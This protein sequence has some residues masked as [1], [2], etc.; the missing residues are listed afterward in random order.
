MA[1]GLC[2]GAG[3]AI[4]GMADPQKVLAFLT[5]GPDWA[6]ALLLVMGSA[7]LT[8][9]L[10]YRL[11]LRRPAPLFATDFSLPVRTAIDR[12]LIV[13]GALF[14]IGW[15]LSGYCPGPAIVGGF[16]LDLRALAF[17][18]TFAIGMTLF[19]VFQRWAS[20]VAPASV[21]DG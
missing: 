8:A 12:R 17:L 13:G 9:T 10:G 4:S 18:G 11:V 6:P 1:A 19:E 15:G 14:G 21:A 7:V 20:P 3:L 5:L 2:F 16:L